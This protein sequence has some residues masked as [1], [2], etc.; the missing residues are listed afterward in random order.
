MPSF[1]DLVALDSNGEP[2]PFENLKG[3]VVVIV[4]VASWCGFTYQYKGLEALNR[5]FEGKDVQLIAF[6]C[7]QFFYQE[8]GSDEKI[9]KFCTRKYGVTFPVLQKI[10]VN[11]KNAHPVYKYLKPKKPGFLGITAVKWNFEKFLINKDGE[12]VERFSTF[13][14]PSTLEG[15]IENLLV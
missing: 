14:R 2:Y 10:D 13:T 11:G 4:N 12:V 15:K 8:P 3:K 5:K 7:N 6:P 9:Q 1:Y